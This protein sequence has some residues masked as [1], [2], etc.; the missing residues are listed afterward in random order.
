MHFLC[1][2]FSRFQRFSHP[3]PQGV[4]GKLEEAIEAYEQ[5]SAKSRA[6]KASLKQVSIQ[7]EQQRAENS[8]LSCQCNAATAD[9]QELR[10]R[11]EA[12][13]TEKETLEADLGRVRRA[14]EEARAMHVGATQECNRIKDELALAN[15]AA[16]KVKKKERN[17]FVC[18]A[19]CLCARA[20]HRIVC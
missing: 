2:I 15:E 6:L 20:V 7:L 11:V 12:L 8:A 13:T 4:S 14:E 18:G 17:Y 10:V 16:R 19:S 3:L 9:A 5:R 1:T